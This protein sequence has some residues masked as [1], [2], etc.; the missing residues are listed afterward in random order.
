M[1]RRVD[2]FS[3]LSKEFRSWWSEHDVVEHRS[4]V[5]RFRHR[6]LGQQAMRIVP[7]FSPEFLPAGIIFHVPVGD[8]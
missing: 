5:R 4:R 1:Q 3:Q 8:E 6:D 2:E 7:M